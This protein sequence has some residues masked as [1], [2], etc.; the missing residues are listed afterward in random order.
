MAET[1]SEIASQTETLKSLQKVVDKGMDRL[2]EQT[3][4]NDKQH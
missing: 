3:L 1:L 2:H 4:A